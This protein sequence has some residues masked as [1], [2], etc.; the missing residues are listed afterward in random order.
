MKYSMRGFFLILLFTATAFTAYSQ[1]AVTIDQAIRFFSRDIAAHLETGTRIAVLNFN[2]ASS[3]MSNHV[4][5]EMNNALVNEGKLTV[6]SRQNLALLQREMNFQLSGDV[7]DETAQSIGR[8]LGA[9]MVITGTQGIAGSN[10]RFRLQVLEVETAAIRYSQTQ[11]VRNDRTVRS[12]MTTASRYDY[13]PA[14]RAGTAALNLALGL[15]SFTIQRDA[16]GGMFTALIEGIGIGLIILSQTEIG[17]SYSTGDSSSFVV[18]EET[19]TMRLYLG[20]AIYGLGA[21]Y[22]VWRA[23]NHHKPVTNVSQS[24]PFPFT[25]AVT[26][27]SRSGASVQLNYTHRF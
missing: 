10:Y 8:L 7:S 17:Y 12:L 3:V 22:G 19:Q 15:G 4:I 14:E 13:T 9:E 20:S 24:A 5:E 25:I 2:S 26:P 23:L 11:D 18:T 27:D 21:V 6:V 1:S 16:S